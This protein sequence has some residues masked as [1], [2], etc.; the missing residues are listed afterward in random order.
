MILLQFNFNC[1][2][3]WHYGLLDWVWELWILQ[4]KGLIE[5]RV[6]RDKSLQT[7][8]TFV[9][10]GLSGFFCPQDSPA[11]YT[12]SLFPPITDVMTATLQR[13]GEREPGAASPLPP[14][15][16]RSEGDSLDVRE[17]VQSL[18]M[19]RVRAA[20]LLVFW[21]RVI[22]PCRDTS[23]DKNNGMQ[24]S[25]TDPLISFSFFF[26]FIENKD[27]DVSTS[28]EP[29][30][31]DSRARWNQ[32]VELLNRAAFNLFLNTNSWLLFHIQ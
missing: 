28:T 18:W 17:V 9:F 23:T 14:P 29:S 8:L 6:S 4:T 2:T 3:Q 27:S 22:L 30:N 16:R 7:N 13:G 12:H 15:P 19:R 20:G 11:A 31:T 10:S 32:D 26:F 21:E 5:D 25:H 1:A 24:D